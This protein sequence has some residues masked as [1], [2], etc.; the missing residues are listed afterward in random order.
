M[1]FYEEIERKD[2]KCSGRMNM[3]RSIHAKEILDLNTI[4][5]FSNNSNHI[6]EAHRKK[7]WN[8]TYVLFPPRR[9]HL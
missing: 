3:E 6:L 1:R 8:M 5:S 9:K 2:G 4:A 7:K